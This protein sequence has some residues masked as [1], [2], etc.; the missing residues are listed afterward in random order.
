MF[1]TCGVGRKLADVLP[2]SPDLGDELDLIGTYAIGPRSNV[3]MGYS[4]FWR[5]NKIL[6]PVDADFYYTQLEVNF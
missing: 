6:A 1:G 4:H 3:L 2:W 5:G